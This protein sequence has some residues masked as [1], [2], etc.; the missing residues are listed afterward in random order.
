MGEKAIKATGGRWLGGG[1]DE[2]DG[3]SGDGGDGNESEGEFEVV[4]KGGERHEFGCKW[5]IN[6]LV[7]ELWD[8]MTKRGY[9]WWRMI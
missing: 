7:Y 5:V 2:K 3:D 4:R 8:K 9:C 6:N 1:G